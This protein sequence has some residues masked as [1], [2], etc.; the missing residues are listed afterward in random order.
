M[1]EQKIG[2]ENLLSIMHNIISLKER[3]APENKRTS[4]TGGSERR[5]NLK[6][7]QGVRGKNFWAT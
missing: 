3:N 7:L 2:R 5:V 4:K 1:S 6:I